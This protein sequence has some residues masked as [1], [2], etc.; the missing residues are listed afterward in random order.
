MKLNTLD[1]LSLLGIL[2]RQG[3]MSTLRIVRDLEHELSFTEAEH[4]ELKFRTADG[5]VHWEP[6][7]DRVKE[8]EFGPRAHRLIEDTLVALDKNKR[9]PFELMSLF[10]RFVPEESDNDKSQKSG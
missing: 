3:D 4:A 8:V 2:P 9:L 1:R 7:A 6:T 10:E 5:R